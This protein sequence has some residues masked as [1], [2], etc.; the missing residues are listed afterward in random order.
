MY[1]VWRHSKRM[2][3]E[4]HHKPQKIPLVNDYAMNYL[5]QK[6]FK[7]SQDV[8]DRKFLAGQISRQMKDVLKMELKE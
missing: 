8:L 1:F 6:H 5:V 4:K 3:N 7:M 2:E